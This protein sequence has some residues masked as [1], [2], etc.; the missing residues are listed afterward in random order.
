LSSARGYIN[1]KGSL[2]GLKKLN[3]ES[4]SR[5]IDYKNVDFGYKNKE[6]PNIPGIPGHILN[7][8]G[9]VD[10]A[11]FLNDNQDM[12]DIDESRKSSIN[13]DKDKLLPNSAREVPYAN[14]NEGR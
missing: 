7:E 10:M 8:Y 14:A 1:S 11:T 3:E 2:N 13:F 6:T 9:K 12:I 4:S 5:R